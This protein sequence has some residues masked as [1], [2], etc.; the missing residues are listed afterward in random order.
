MAYTY[1]QLFALA[2][3]AGLSDKPGTD[4]SGGGAAG[5]ACDVAAA[6]ALAESG[7]NPN[8]H[9][10]TPPDDSYGLWQINMY[11][12]LGPARRQQ[13]GLSSNSQLFDPAT[14][15]RAMA[16]ISNGGRSW[17][18]WTTYTSGRYKDF[19]QGLQGHKLS[20][21]SP[22]DVAV[23]TGAAV[24]GPLGDT[25]G[26]IEAIGHFFSL[27]TQWS[28]WQRIL[29]V[30]GGAVLLGAAIAIATKRELPIPTPG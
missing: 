8:S 28:T 26:G 4:P 30:A 27:L 7:G 18:A 22:G 23:A 13:F 12:N 5:S 15:A 1:E 25:L 17:S 10:T 24:A 3:S 14:N 21:T 6:V 19:Y 16:T 9:N 11:G 20:P 29:E 2:K